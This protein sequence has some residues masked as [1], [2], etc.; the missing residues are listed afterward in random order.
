MN[1]GLAVLSGLREVAAHKLRSLLTMLGV[2]LGVTSLVTMFAI[3]AGMARQAYENLVALGGLTLVGIAEEE[4]SEELRPLLDVSPGR[5]MRDVEAIRV[6]IPLVEHIS[7][8]VRMNVEIDYGNFNNRQR[9]EGIASDFFYAHEHEMAAGRFISELDNINARNVVVLGHSLAQEIFRTT[10]PDRVLGQTIRI[11]QRPYQVVGILKFYERETDRR[12]RLEEEA[13]RAAQGD[14]QQ[15]SSVRRARERG[16][17][18]YH[19]KNQSLLIPIN[20]FL[21]EFR[22]SNVDANGVD[23]GPNWRLEELQIKL[24]NLDDFQA[25]LGQ[26]ESL[27]LQTHRGIDDFSFSTQE[28]WFDQIER[29]VSATRLTGSVIAG[30]SLVVGGIGIANIMLASITERVREIGIRM[31]VGARRRDVF[32]QILSESG[33]IGLLGG[34]FGLILAL[35][36]IRVLD[37]AGASDVAPIVE[38]PSL[39]IGFSF[40]VVVGLVAGIYPAWKASRLEPIEAL[41]Y[42]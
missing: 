18:P 39:V 26:L 5:T 20:R 38:W 27:L 17:N 3:T 6:G 15:A 7:P 25:V 31:A 8:E 35:G 13:R 22:A 42:E 21:Q 1:F 16:W 30:I 33:L 9:V 23:W 29:S 2:I 28:G 24:R 34:A 14:Q 10:D 11:R 32:I 12:R 4:P 40:A 37:V 19:R 36:L 41:R